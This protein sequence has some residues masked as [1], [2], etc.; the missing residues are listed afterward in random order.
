MLTLLRISG[1]ALIDEVEIGFGPGLTVI[2]GETGAGKSILVQALGVLRGGRAGPDLIRSGADEARVEAILELPAS[3]PMRAR[4][5]DDGREAGDADEGLVVRRVIARGAGDGRGRARAHAHLGGS[6]ATSADLA[7]VVGRLVDIASQHDQQS[8]TS[9][10]AQLAILDAFAEDPA[11]LAE[12]AAA[13]EAKRAAET[14]LAAFAG[15]AR[16]RAER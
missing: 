14:A 6:I 3:S 8:L 4:L 15:D 13:F 9:P 5:A 12:M 11:V 2:T 16:A 7:A 10:D 1:F